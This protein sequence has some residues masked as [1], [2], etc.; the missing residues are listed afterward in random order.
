MRARRD[1]D[2]WGLSAGLRFA[3]GAR[4]AAEVGYGTAVRGTGL[5][6]IALRRSLDR[7]RRAALASRLAAAASGRDVPALG[8]RGPVRGR[9]RPCTASRS[10][11]TLPALV[12]D[13]SRTQDRCSAG[14][15]LLTRTAERKFASE[16]VPCRIRHGF[17]TRGWTV[18]LIRC[19]DAGPGVGHRVQPSRSLRSQRASMGNG[20]LSPMTAANRGMPLR[21]AWGGGSVLRLGLILCAPL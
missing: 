15:G 6:G 11:S 16:W 21:P 2:A 14:S 9:R 8:G 20:R 5:A 1:R 13:Y 4:L 17:H 12:R 7:G 19:A 3:P 18:S 10:G